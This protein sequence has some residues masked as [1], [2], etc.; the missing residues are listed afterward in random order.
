M[1]S[2]KHFEA[3]GKML[4]SRAFLAL[5]DEVGL[6]Y[7]GEARADERLFEFE[8]PMALFQS[9][10]EIEYPDSDG[11]RFVA[12]EPDANQALHCQTLG[13]MLQMQND[14]LLISDLTTGKPLLTMAEAE[15][16][17]KVEVEN[18]QLRAE[19]RRLRGEA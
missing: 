11:N 2:A 3:I 12:I 14:D 17:K 10:L 19:L 6:E 18:E 1:P 8:Q 4:T 9:N 16:R 13:L 15:A 5:L 7:N